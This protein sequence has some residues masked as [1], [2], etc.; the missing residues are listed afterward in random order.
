[1]RAV[2]VLVGV[3]G[4]LVA[5]CEQEKKAVQKAVVEDPGG[6]RMTKARADALSIANAVRLYQAAEGRLPDS[7]GALTA[8]PAPVLHALPPPPPGWTEWQYRKNPDGLTFSISSSGDNT[9]VLVN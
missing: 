5:G 6:A 4:L 2:I 7:L 8:G 9:T 3:L 1:M